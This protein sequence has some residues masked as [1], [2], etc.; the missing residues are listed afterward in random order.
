MLSW[1]D[2]IYD[3][4][5]IINKELS[6]V[7]NDRGKAFTGKI[8]EYFYT[9]IQRTKHLYTSPYTFKKDFSRLT[10]EEKSDWH[11]F[12][13]K[14]PEK[15]SSLNLCIRKYGEF[16]RTCLIPYNEL[17]KMAQ[18]DYELFIS[19]N[20]YSKQIPKA[21]KA[22]ENDLIPFQDLPEKR[23]RFFIELN[24]L[25]PVELKKT[26]YEV[27]RLE[28]I[29]E[30]DDKMVARLARAIHSRY[31]NEM[32]KLNASTEKR[33]YISWILN[34]GD[35]QIA[36]FDRLPEEI[37]HSNL[38]NAFH[39]PTK[40][41]SIGYK[42]R[43]V[44][45][46]FKSA[47]LHLTEEEVETMAR[48]EHIRWCWDKILHGWFYGS[49]KDS[50]KKIHP[51]IIPYED[52]SEPE[53]E[54]DRELVRMIPALLK[55]IDYEAYPV[56]RNRLKKLS[57]AI[58]PH[59][60]IERILH[61]IRELNT[62]IKSMIDLPPAI[63]EILGLRNRKIEDAI[64]EVEGS[65]TIAQR[66]QGTYLPDDLF[67]RE[68]LP[69]SFV[70]FKPKDIV[71]GD[72]YF[73]S[74]Q[75]NLIIF[76]AADCTGHGI[77]GAL[78]STLGYGI[79]D[80]AVNE[81]RLTD[82]FSILNHLYTKIHRFLGNDTSGRGLSDDMDIALCILDIKTNIL[83]YAGVI[84]PLY[85]ISN[86]ELIEYKPRN[87]REHFGEKGKNLFTSE[88]IQLSLNDTLYLFT[89]GYIDQFGGKYRKKYQSSRFKSFLMSIQEL[90]MPEQ[91][92]RLNE[93]IEA[94]REEY[95]EDQTDDILVIGVRI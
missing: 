50:K 58:R 46:G 71:S 7:W 63:D 21:K 22:S 67:I 19:K 2:I 36:D 88:K 73:F 5:N 86:G 16:C 42:I 34:H 65:Y 24:H 1:T 95:N 29:T 85:R 26:G 12:A 20:S 35:K 62:Q 27:I 52:L 89:D 44:E 47:A 69:D 72:F 51:S 30:I 18:A 79:L 59:G 94:W 82:P 90:S 70:L 66:I 61:E 74:K 78:L 4:D 84:N 15:L 25:I 76:A 75:C 49:V 45:K 83:T 11:A 37:K 54:K 3:T 64:R 81:I 23:K 93:E 53:K 10:D 68:C 40:L 38:D 9:D 57:Y 60:S 41:L 56:N 77:P 55:D 28:E 80:Q 87:L 14:I 8:A 32:R 48:V 33:I 92:D 13:S 91:S 31:Q 17:Q 6:S 39:I 43:P